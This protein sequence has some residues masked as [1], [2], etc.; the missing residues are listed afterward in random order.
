MKLI[1]C[2]EC[3]SMVVLNYDKKTCPCGLSFGY[4]KDQ[5][6][7]VFGGLATPVGI[8][9]P[10]LIDAA[11]RFPRKSTAIRAWVDGPVKAESWE[12]EK[13]VR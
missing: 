3:R 6:N 10:D 13:E 12:F 8:A 2:V 1:Y 11:R 9:N 4:Y 7:A 5:S